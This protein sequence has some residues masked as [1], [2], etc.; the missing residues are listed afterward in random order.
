M[1]NSQ[2]YKALWNA[3]NVDVICHI[4]KKIKKC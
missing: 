3:F 2:R 4:F 1:S